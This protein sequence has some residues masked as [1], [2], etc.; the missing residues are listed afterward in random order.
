MIKYLERGSFRRRRSWPQQ[1][2]TAP[3]TTRRLKLLLTTGH[4]QTP[5]HSREKFRSFVDFSIARKRPLLPLPFNLC[6]LNRVPG[7][8]FR[9]FE[10]FEVI[11]GISVVVPISRYQLQATMSSCG[12]YRGSK[13]DLGRAAFSRSRP[14]Q[15]EVS[16]K[17][18]KT[19]FILLEFPDVNDNWGDENAFL[20]FFE[21]DIFTFGLLVFLLFFPFSLVVLSVF[22]F[23]FF[24]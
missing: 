20:I 5:S 4:N 3:V 23:T 7:L 11:R 24:L 1:K 17:L 18:Q 8:H 9:L 10:V 15:E 22:N 12:N 16:T 14:F 6:K 21:L 19:S 2:L 13:V